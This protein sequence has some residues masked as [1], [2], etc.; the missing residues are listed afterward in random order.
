[1]TRLFV[2]VAMVTIVGGV[3]SSSPMVAQVLP[4]A[5]QAEHVEII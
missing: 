1:M 4:P 3:L 5:K 2:K